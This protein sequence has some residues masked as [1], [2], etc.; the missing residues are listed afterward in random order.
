MK[1]LARVGICITLCIVLS[2]FAIGLQV[3]MDLSS[4]ED[5]VLTFTR[6]SMKDA[7][8]NIQTTEQ[9]GYDYLKGTSSTGYSNVNSGKYLFGFAPYNYTSHG[10]DR[11]R[12]YL[13]NLFTKA[14]A[15]GVNDANMQ[16]ITSFL[17]SNRESTSKDA[18]FRP[19]QYGMTFVDP[20]LFVNSFAESMEQLVAANYTKAT[21]YSVGGVSF[22][23]KAPCALEITN[24]SYK[25]N[26]TPFKPGTSSGAIQPALGTLKLN[27]KGGN[28]DAIYRS[29]YGIDKIVDSEIGADLGF[30]SSSVNFFVYYDIEVTVEWKSASTNQLLTRNFFTNL[31]DKS[32][33]A[34]ADNNKVSGG[35]SYTPQVDGSQEYVYIPGKPVTYSYRYV[36]IN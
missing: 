30:G 8:V 2:F 33:N 9:E 31:A 10:S 14:K 6:L 29:I 7:L 17:Q 35:L 13:S 16:V 5:D 20:Q 24:I 21:Q 27:N 36:L 15:S 26:G 12:A 4:R 11:Y 3:W 32:L 25:I 18:L 23:T 1:N 22:T 19:I 28:A 34:F